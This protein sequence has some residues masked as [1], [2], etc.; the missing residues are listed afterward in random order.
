MQKRYQNYNERFLLD[1]NI[2]DSDY[3]QAFETLTEVNE[4]MQTLK[5][6]EKELDMILLERSE[7]EYTL[8]DSYRAVTSSKVSKRDW[9]E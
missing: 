7:D 5:V 6:K 8:I 3:I 4:T 1:V 9:Y 2:G